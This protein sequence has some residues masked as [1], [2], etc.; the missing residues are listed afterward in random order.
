MR[1]TIDEEKIPTKTE[2]RQLLKATRERAEA[3]RAAGRRQPVVDHII[4]DLMI[5]SGLR[6]HEIV[7]LK[8]RDLLVG[9]GRSAI[10]VRH[11]K[12]DKP[13]IAAISTR[14]KNHLRKFLKWKAGRGE[15][16][17]DES[18]V[19]V[20]QRGGQL[21]T[22][23]IRYLFKRSLVRAGLGNKY[24]AHC[25]R[26]FHLSALYGSTNDIRLVQ[27]QAGHASINTTQVYTHISLDRRQQAVDRIF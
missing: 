7:D 21:T 5:S 14:L 3:A 26:H 12:G 13:R 17:E 19:F 18:L 6:S 11:G 4:L 22:R 1:W 8:I 15:S 2:V 24:S 9:H 23:G 16:C 27:E 25:T 20:S 10:A